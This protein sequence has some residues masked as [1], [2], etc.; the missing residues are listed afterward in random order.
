[1]KL[2]PAA[3]E[4][5]GVELEPVGQGGAEAGPLV[6]G[7][8]A[9]AVELEVRTVDEEAVVGVPADMADAERHLHAVN[10]RIT[11]IEAEHDAIE[12]R[13]GRLPEAGM[14]E[15][16]SGGEFLGFPGGDSCGEF[17]GGNGLA[18]GI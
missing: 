14:G 5:Q 7:F 13:V 17:G 12:M 4:L 8:L 11:N 15:E 10:V 16:E 2:P 1:M 9:P 6:G 3:H 18:V